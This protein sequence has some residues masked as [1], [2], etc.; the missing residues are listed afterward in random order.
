MTEQAIEVLCTLPFEQAQVQLLE[1]A[2]PRLHITLAPAR[3]VEDIAPETWAKTEVLYTDRLLPPPAQVPML[4]WLQFHFAGIDFALESPLV[5]KPGLLVTTLSG[6]AA[7]QAAEH[8]LMAMLA[9]GHHLPEIC[10]HQYRAEWPRDRGE[11]FIPRELRNATVGIVGYGSI[12]RELARLLKVFNVTVLAVKRDVMKP[13]DPGYAYPGLGDAS[14]D[15]FTRL[16][17]VQAVKSMLRECDFVVLALPLSAQTRGV[18]GAEELAVMKPGAFLVDIGR[19]GVVDQ[20]A[21]VDALVE[22]RIAGAAL[23]VFSEEPLPAASPLWK[24]PNLIITPHIAGISPFY[25]ERAATLFAENLR[26]Y[27]G[28]LPLL[29]LY[30]AERGY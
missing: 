21:L 3:R 5:Q 30:D 29:N 10:A 20:A 27:S 7:P 18:I 23:D 9:L 24:L 4:R 25:L 17:P 11:R 12:G 19:G 15:L 6:A 16:Y 26:R 2:S 28:G 14:G 8:V 13:A 1:A 22:K